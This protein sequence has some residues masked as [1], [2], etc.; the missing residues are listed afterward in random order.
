MYSVVAFAV[1]LVSGPITAVATASSSP[2]M[3]LL[4]RVTIFSFIVWMA[5]ASVVLARDVR[6]GGA[7]SWAGLP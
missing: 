7:M 6:R 2:F 1:I 5:I 4:E 3:G